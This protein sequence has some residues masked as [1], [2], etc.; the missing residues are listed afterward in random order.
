[1][2]GKGVDVLNGFGGMI[3]NG[4]TKTGTEVH[5]STKVGSG[6]GAT[7]KKGGKKKI[8]KGGKY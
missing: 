6:N 4:S 7:T 8:K 3:R 2:A 5:P 1:M